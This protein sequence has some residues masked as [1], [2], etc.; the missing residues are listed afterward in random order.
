VDDGQR[1]GV[2]Y[3]IQWGDAMRRRGFLN[4]LIGGVAASAAVRT[5]PFRVYSFPSE[6][7]QPEFPGIQFVS[8]EHL[9]QFLEK[10]LPC[11]LITPIRG[12]VLIDSVGVWEL[13]F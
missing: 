6:I 13:D 2:E 11:R 9:K 1:E 7:R 5:W 8:T 12:G 10:E 3:G 4:T